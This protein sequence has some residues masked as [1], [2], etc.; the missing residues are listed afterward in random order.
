MSEPALSIVLPVFNEERAI[1]E[2]LRRIRAFLTLKGWNAEI[3]VASDGSTD[4]TD[5]IVAEEAA[6]DAR[7]RL[8]SA[9]ENR[10]KGAAARRG[11]LAAR[12]RRIL[13]TDCDLS[14]PIKEI[15][16]LL[17][18][19]ERGADVAI[20]S[21]AVCSPG[22]DVRQSPKRRLAGRVFNF[23]VTMLVV[24]G[25]RDTQCGFKLFTREAAAQLFSRQKLD[26]FAFD[27]ELLY[28]ARRQGLR[29]AEVPVMWG[30]GPDTK[31]RLV[32]DSTRMLGDLIRIPRLHKGAGR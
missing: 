3:L 10:G 8:I 27:V 24:R 30:E 4:A 6:R 19:V 1:G 9:P 14:A 29:I 28:L 2:A 17:A 32:R 22:A 20:G 7:V 5:R 26:G 12:G 11:A 21:R 31:I 16:K 23:F 13:L 15:D 18:A 25:F